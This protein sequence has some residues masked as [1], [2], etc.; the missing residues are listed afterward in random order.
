MEGEI[1]HLFI[2]EGLNEARTK[3]LGNGMGIHYA[4]ML[5]HDRKLSEQIFSDGAMCAM[6]YS[7]SWGIN[8]MV[9]NMHD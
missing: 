7:N 1:E 2:E 8:L 3:S 6:L 4:G 9:G 5:R